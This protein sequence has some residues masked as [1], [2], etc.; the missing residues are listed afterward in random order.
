MRADPTPNSALRRVTGMVSRDERA[1]VLATDAVPGRTLPSAPHADAPG[2]VE[3]TRRELA[4]WLRR[5]LRQ[6]DRTARER[7]AELAGQLAT[8]GIA[9]TAETL[10]DAVAAVSDDTTVAVS[11]LQ[12][13]SLLLKEITRNHDDVPYPGRS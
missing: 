13:A 10:A 6:Q 7:M 5:G 3:Q 2:P 8:A 9:T 12:R 11:Q 1:V 4:D